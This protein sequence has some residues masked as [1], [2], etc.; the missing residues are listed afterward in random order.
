MRGLG[1]GLSPTLAAIGGEPAPVPVWSDD[2]VSDWTPINVTLGTSAF[3]D[4]EIGAAGVSVRETVTDAQ[5]FIYKEIPLVEDS[6][7]RLR[8]LIRGA[9]RT[10]INVTLGGKY[11]IGVFATA[12][13][14]LASGFSNATAET[15][16]DYTA[17]SVEYTHEAA[18]GLT[19]ITIGICTLPLATSYPGDITKGLE[20][21]NVKLYDIT[22]PAPAL[23]TAVRFV[24]GAQFRRSAAGLAVAGVVGDFSFGAW[25]RIREYLNQYGTFLSLQKLG[26]PGELGSYFFFGHDTLAGESPGTRG[27]A[28]YDQHGAHSREVIPMDEWVHIKLTKTGANYQAWI[29]DTICDWDSGASPNTTF[30]GAHATLN[31]IDAIC[32][33]DEAD[34]EDSH[35][36]GDIRAVYIRNG[37]MTLVEHQAEAIKSSPLAGDPQAVGSW[38]FDEDD[39]TFPDANGGA[40]FTNFGPGGTETIDDGPAEITEP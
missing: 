37:S 7:Y 33:G 24:D 25:F 23:T 32:T 39:A 11:W 12:T 14:D 19:G 30:A 28:I 31:E 17:F 27:L 3:T 20:V 4:P 13:P 6:V 5:H 8:F 9:S 26:S 18:S 40:A 34:Y 36:D 2:N 29:N 15:V 1:I 21:G 10:T 16:G 22:P 38:A 35:F